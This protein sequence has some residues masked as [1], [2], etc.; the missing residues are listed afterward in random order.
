MMLFDLCICKNPNTPSPTALP[1][2]TLAII[3][4]VTQV[5]YTV[6]SAECQIKV[7]FQKAGG[8]VAIKRTGIF[9]SPRVFL[10]T[11]HT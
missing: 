9:F 5:C 3:I 2:R 4:L 8:E 6:Y 10:L 1:S 11:Y 7:C